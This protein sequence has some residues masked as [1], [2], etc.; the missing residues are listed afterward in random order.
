MYCMKL[1][2]R[3]ILLSC[4]SYM[5]PAVCCAQEL[6]PFTTVNVG[7]YISPPFV[8]KNEAGFYTG[9]AIDIWEQIENELNIKT[10]YTEFDT[11]NGLMQA[12]TDGE[13]DI[14]VSNI[15]V[16][17]G[18]AEMLKFSFPWYDSGLRIMVKTEGSRSVWNELKRS[19]HIEAYAGIVLIIL[20]L[21][22][23]LTVIQRKRDPEFPRRWIDG[24]AE[25]LYRL[26]LAIKTGVV[27]NPSYNWIGKV[28]A[29]TWMLFG[30]GL[31]AYITSSIT[32]SMTAVTL[33][34]DIHSFA[35]LPGKT[36][37]VLSNSLA[38][39]YLNDRDI[40]TVPYETIAELTQ[41]LTNDEVNAV[42]DDAPTLE[43]WCYNHPE[44]KTKVVGDIFHDDK[45]AFG[46]NKENSSLMDRISVE[47]IKMF[48]LGKVAE[49][50]N[51]Y[52]GNIH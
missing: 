37:G 40:R 41:A 47:L 10:K 8:M 28:L 16:T 7:V 39:K 14:A 35:D 11:W 6:L 4:L 24:L 45:F 33:I 31:V 42:V 44:R 27:N 26:I 2:S 38:E 43:Y 1:L 3:L 22:I 19:G 32:S 51:K 34:H 17:Y 49:I 20:L 29:V 50:R 18:R 30:I 25:S 48:D 46:A 12:I 36:V 5:V 21:T 23:I 9:M 13:I 15:S 52:F